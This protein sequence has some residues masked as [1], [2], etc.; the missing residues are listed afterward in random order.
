MKIQLEELARA[1]QKEEQD[2][3]VANERIIALESELE[4]SRR[5]I[6]LPIETSK[7]GD[8]TQAFEAA[9]EAIDMCE[10]QKVKLAKYR[11][12]CDDLQLKV[13]Q[14]EEDL[15]FARDEKMVFEGVNE[16]LDSLK[17]EHFSL[18]SEVE[19]SRLSGLSSMNDSIL[20]RSETA[21]AELEAARDVLQEKLI[22]KTNAMTDQQVKIS[23]FEKT[24]TEKINEISELTIQLEMERS[25]SSNRIKE[26][27]K[28]LD[29]AWKPSTEIDV[30][31]AN[32]QTDND[33]VHISCQATVESADCSV[34]T[35]A[36][37]TAD[38]TIQTD[39]VDIKFLNGQ[40]LHKSRELT[41]AESTLETLRVKIG[42]QIIK[43]ETSIAEIATKTEDI[44]QLRD[45]AHQKNAELV[46][47]QQACGDHQTAISEKQLEID[48]LVSRISNEER[49]NGDL[50]NNIQNL[51]TVTESVEKHKQEALNEMTERLG[52]LEVQLKDKKDALENVE[53]MFKECQM[54]LATV[55]QAT[56]AVEQEKQALASELCEAKQRLGKYEEQIFKEPADPKPNLSDLGIVDVSFGDTSSLQ[57]VPAV[58]GKDMSSN[59][60][61]TNS[62]L[63]AMGICEEYDVTREYDVIESTPSPVKTVTVD[64]VSADVHEVKLQQ[65]K[66]DNDQLQVKITE[67]TSVQV[68]NETLIATIAELKMVRTQ[69]ESE[70]TSLTTQVGDLQTV[71]QMKSVLET[72]LAE[73]KSKLSI[74]ETSSADCLDESLAT[75]KQELA[76]S[77][78]TNTGLLTT[79]SELKAE[80]SK[81]SADKTE[82]ST[83]IERLT[84]EKELLQSENSNLA[85]DKRNHDVSI[86]SKDT[87]ILEQRNSV[88]V[89][90]VCHLKREKY[91]FYF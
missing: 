46:R 29:H 22:E 68:E 54:S 79:I 70:V 91:I 5:Q 10:E 50:L 12:T 15:E 18:K 82:I 89:L 33:S 16:E 72:Q 60:L 86:D 64:T 37:N 4:E 84:N 55:H 85:V 36:T 28:E 43:I 11:T 62:D 1:L 13:K 21:F 73:L 51:K 34:A 3:L 17:V 49:K 20:R 32:T 88:E 23:E 27:T 40:L 58:H 8:K 81:L 63:S 75:M 87:L 48:N 39:L 56:N 71:D 24:N 19:N 90:Q 9:A 44:L 80:N 47:A 74:S 26:L 61:L 42:E 69:L 41:Q 2:K 7:P 83:V 38:F 67:M 6:E 59:N 57:P 45:E 65:L 30:A 53:R 14:L 76:L 25:K 35:T 78:E 52:A 66:H 31:T 77:Q